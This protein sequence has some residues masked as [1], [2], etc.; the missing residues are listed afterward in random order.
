MHSSIWCAAG[1]P[2]TPMVVASPVIRPDAEDQH[3]RLGATLA[4][5]RS[6]IEARIER[7]AGFD[8]RLTSYVG[9]PC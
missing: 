7:R 1:H 8:P 5:L 4:D 2:D 3:N 6:V 9:V